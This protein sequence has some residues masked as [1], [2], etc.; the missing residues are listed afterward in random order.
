M[1]KVKEVNPVVDVEAFEEGKTI[2]IPKGTEVKPVL[3]TE[4]TPVK[5]PKVL[6][7]VDDGKRSKLMLRELADRGIDFVEIKA[8][9]KELEK[10]VPKIVE[11]NKNQTNV[12][13]LPVT[14]TDYNKNSQL[15]AN[16]KQNA[17]MPVNLYFDGHD[18]QEISNRCF[19]LKIE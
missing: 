7:I 15:Y 19:R 11:K 9:F 3:V 6:A 13:Y 8:N 10:E 14:N 17:G 5:D 12:V 2:V 4:N 18:D 1:V 16:I